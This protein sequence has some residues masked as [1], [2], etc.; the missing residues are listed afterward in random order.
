MFIFDNAT[1]HTAFTP[2]ALRVLN[3]NLSSGGNQNH[4]MRDGWNTL[5]QQSQPMYTW[6]RGRKVAKGVRKVL[7]ERGLWRPG[8]TLKPDTPYFSTRTDTDRP[9]SNVKL[10]ILLHIKSPNEC[11]IQSV[12]WGVTVVQLQSSQ[13]RKISEVRALACKRL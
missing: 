4:N 8:K 3:M 9:V 12:Y 11:Q 6:V 10:T 2:D 13:H 5:T 1:N 7:E